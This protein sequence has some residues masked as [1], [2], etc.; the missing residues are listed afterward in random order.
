[1]GTGPCLQP[2]LPRRPRQ[3][4]CDGGAAQDALGSDPLVAARA[5]ELAGLGKSDDGSELFR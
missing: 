5:R 3:S 4:L 2:A 1:M